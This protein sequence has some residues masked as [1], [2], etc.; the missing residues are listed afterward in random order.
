M[1]SVYK[2]TRAYCDDG[3]AQHPDLEQN[4]SDVLTLRIVQPLIMGQRLEIVTL[5]KDNSRF[6]RVIECEETSLAQRNGLV[7]PPKPIDI[8]RC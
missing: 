4:E 7:L 5:T 6:H 8:N 1:P 3:H 2:I